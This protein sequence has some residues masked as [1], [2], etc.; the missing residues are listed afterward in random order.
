MFQH[1]Q[2]PEGFEFPACAACNHGSDDHDLL[3]AMLARMDPLEEK[4]DL[5]GRLEGLMKAVHRQYPRLFPKMALSANEARRRNRELGLER[6]PGQT[7]QERGAVRVTE[8]FDDAVRVLATKLAKGVY[9][10][11]TGRV[12]PYDGALLFRWFTNVELVRDG[13]YEVFRKLS[14]IA[15]GIPK[16]QR[17]Q[18]LLNDQFEY[19]WSLSP[20]K[21]VFVLQAVF[22]KAFGLVVFGSA[23]PGVL[24]EAVASLRDRTGNNG[25]FTVLQSPTLT[26]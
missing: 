16:L 23:K 24:E 8:E 15:G 6:A 14:G 10:R 5:D 7:H 4:G 11:E 2:W 20:D 17:S 12:F 25:P 18:K 26:S 22:G 19:K 9:Y 1:R 13:E 21:D 3:V